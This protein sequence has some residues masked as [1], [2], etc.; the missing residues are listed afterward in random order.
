M[1]VLQKNEL[2][3]AET[4]ERKTDIL[5][6]TKNKLGFYWEIFVWEQNTSGKSRNNGPTL[7]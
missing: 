1:I 5:E 2:W 4:R 7:T 3:E 6:T